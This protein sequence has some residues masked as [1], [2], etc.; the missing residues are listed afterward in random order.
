MAR[1]FLAVIVVG[2]AFTCLSLGLRFRRRRTQSTRLDEGDWSFVGL[3]VAA[4]A[5]AI[6]LWLI[7]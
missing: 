5:L 1:I 2:V 4:L 3:I 6:V 7:Q